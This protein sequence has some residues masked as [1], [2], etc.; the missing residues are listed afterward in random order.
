LQDKGV[1]VTASAG[2]DLGQ[3]GNWVIG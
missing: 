3:G 2:E 1:D